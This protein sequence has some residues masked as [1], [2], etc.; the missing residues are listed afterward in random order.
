MLAETM[1]LDSNL[2]HN[3]NAQPLLTWLSF[4]VVMGL[5]FFSYEKV[6]LVVIFM[7]FCCLEHNYYDVV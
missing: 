5:C 2:V 3:W 7:L 1:L 4:E 6:F